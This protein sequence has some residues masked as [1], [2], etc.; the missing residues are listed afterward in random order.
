MHLSIESDSW[1]AL[2]SLVTPFLEP[3]QGGNK[4]SLFLSTI[5][6]FGRVLEF[7]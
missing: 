6:P 3:S 1:S 4:E 7:T 5:Q 2:Q